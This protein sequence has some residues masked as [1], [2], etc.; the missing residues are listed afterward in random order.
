MTFE[1][2]AIAAVGASGP[3]MATVT[4]NPQILTDATGVSVTGAAV[5]ILW[6]LANSITEYMREIEKHRVLEVK[7][8][9]AAAEHRRAECA[10]WSSKG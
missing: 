3:L 4:Q 7:Q 5:L 8:W 1:T 2:A 9:D 10:Y 6:K